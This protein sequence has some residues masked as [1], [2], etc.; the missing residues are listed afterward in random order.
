MFDFASARLAAA[1]KPRLDQLFANSGSFSEA[2]NLSGG[3]AAANASAIAN[4]GINEVQQNIQMENNYR[5]QKQ[6]YSDKQI[7]ADVAAA[8]AT[9]GNSNR[10]IAGAAGALSGGVTAQGTITNQEQSALRNNNYQQTKNT[11]D[12]R[13][14]KNDAWTNIINNVGG[15]STAISLSLIHISTR[16]GIWTR[17][18]ASILRLHSHRSRAYCRP[19]AGRESAKL[20]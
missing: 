6:G 10:L 18:G 17:S 16:R 13:A 14:A 1:A 8:N 11:V 2:V 15:A 9:R 12:W 7:T 3:D 20:Y 5:M 4:L 19:G